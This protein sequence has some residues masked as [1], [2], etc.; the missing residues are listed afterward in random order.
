M[1]ED[2]ETIQQNCP[3][4]TVNAKGW[5]FSYL[6][7]NIDLDDVTASETETFQYSDEV[8]QVLEAV[9][10]DECLLVPLDSK[11]IGKVNKRNKKKKKKNITVNSLCVTDSRDV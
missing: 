3:S 8:I 11:Y 1:F 4:E 2:L 7:P 9:N 5:S 10:D 6:E